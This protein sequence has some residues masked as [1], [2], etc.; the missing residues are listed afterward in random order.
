MAHAYR[1]GEHYLES[2]SI[3]NNATEWAQSDELNTAKY[4]KC[5]FSA[6]SDLYFSLQLTLAEKVYQNTV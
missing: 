1:I 5:V 4:W 2:L 6:E 3:L